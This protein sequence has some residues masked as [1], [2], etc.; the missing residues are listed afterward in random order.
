MIGYTIELQ[1]Q[2]DYAFIQRI[3][4]EVTQ[5]CAL[6][7]ALPL[8]RIPEYIRQAADYFFYNYDQASEERYYIIKNSEVNK[9]NVFNKIVQLPH[10]IISVFGVYK[11]Q[12]NTRFSTAGDFS[13]E[14]L[15]LSSYSMFGGAGTVGQG[16]NGMSGAPG[17]TLSDMVVSMLEVSTFN[18]MLN[19]PLSYN[20]NIHSSKLVLLGDLGT[21]DI[22]ICCM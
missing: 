5:S 8:E 1:N 22:L 18:E 6:P 20:Y 10:Q 2:L 13:V 9:C 14:R 11:T 19:A 15:L 7:F 12:Q 17:Y 4:D 16:M 3:Q 21:S